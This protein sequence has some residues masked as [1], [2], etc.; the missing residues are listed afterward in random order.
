MEKTK[1]IFNKTPQMENIRS[2][3]VSRDDAEKLAACLN[4][5]SEDEF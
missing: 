2:T 5:W 1:I 4:T 3:E